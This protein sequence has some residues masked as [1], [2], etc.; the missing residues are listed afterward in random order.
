MLR[1]IL[2][3]V[4]VVAVLCSAAPA[5]A[6]QGFEIHG[7]GG[8][9]SG[10]GFNIDSNQYER[11]GIEEGGVL[12][13]GIGYDITD[14]LQVEFIW[15]RGLSEIIGT[16]NLGGGQIERLGDNVA[17][18]FHGNLVFEFGDD[19]EFV[20]YVFAGLGAT[21]FAPEDLEA[22]MRFSWDAGF[23]LKWHLNETFGLRFQG[24]FVSN[25]MSADQDLHCDPDTNLCLSDDVSE[26][27]FLFEGTGGLII[28]F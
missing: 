27:L 3:L 13:A 19:D 11:L 28:R 6:Q 2:P 22:E 24:R 10:G 23:G 1:R 21:R 16:L 12:G 20:Q 5:W 4:L 25:Y 14:N 8:F 9:R 18:Q 26:W 17:D 7:F 15:S